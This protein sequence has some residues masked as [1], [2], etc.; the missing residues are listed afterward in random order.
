MLK[1]VTTENST[2]IYDDKLKNVICVAVDEV[3]RRN[4]APVPVIWADKPMVG[5][6]WTLLTGLREDGVL[7]HLTTSRVIS[8][9]P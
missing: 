9:K 5:F 4:G 6:P 2:Y 3:R 8:I 7:A 1:V